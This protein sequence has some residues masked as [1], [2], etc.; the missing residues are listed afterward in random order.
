VV[1]VVVDAPSS[2]LP[3]QEMTVRLKRNMDKM[4]SICLTWFPIRVVGYV[5]IY[6]N[7]EDFTTIGDFTW[8]VV[9]L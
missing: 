4:M 3:A 6:H 2:L 8:S 9:R 7:L 1:E 5:N